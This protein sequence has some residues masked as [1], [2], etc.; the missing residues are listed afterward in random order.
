VSS[1]EAII[2]LQRA[3]TT[4]AVGIRL[5]Q[6]TH[7]V[8]RSIVCDIVLHDASV[9][10]RHAELLIDGSAVTIRDLNSR[11]GTFV[12]EMPIQSRQL[13][14]GERIR[15]GSVSLVI[16]RFA[17]GDL[18]DVETSNPIEFQEEQPTS[19]TAPDAPLSVGQRRVFDLLLAGLSEKDVAVRLELSRHTVHS[20]VREIY[21]LL[22]VRTRSELLARFVRAIGEREPS[23]P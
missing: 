1:S 21:R 4:A 2:L 7:T 15:L 10:R 5:D 16:R 12:D 14:F 13:V 8:G 9:S 23:E 22:N 19:P 20:H 17:A 3:E 6:G 18:A 11:N